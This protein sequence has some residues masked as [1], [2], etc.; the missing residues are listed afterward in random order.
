MIFVSYPPGGSG[1]KLGRII[2]TSKKFLYPLVIDITK[3]GRKLYD[4]PIY[5]AYQKKLSWQAGFH[6]HYL[7]K[8]NNKI[9]YQ[10]IL[11]DIF[12]NKQQLDLNEYFIKN[13]I[14]CQHF[15][16]DKIEHIF[17]NPKCIII[18]PSN[19]E[20]LYEMLNRM[21]KFEA[22]KTEAF[23]TGK[24]KVIK[25]SSD[26]KKPI[27]EQVQIHSNLLNTKLND[28]YLY[29]QWGEILNVTNNLK[30]KLEKFLLVDDIDVEPF[31]IY[32][33]KTDDEI[34]KI[35]NDYWGYDE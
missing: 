3:E 11:I 5:G 35:Q 25:Y 12:V 1:H 17:S 28:N 27:D 29:L 20:E 6:W 30:D 22:I 8:N 23:I 15:S 26:L 33:N 31:K 14:I 21:N 32:N 18:Q 2:G 13:R 7:D 10:R 24:I 19:K 16:P 34:L 9:D 4:N